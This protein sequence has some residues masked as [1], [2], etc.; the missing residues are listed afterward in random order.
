MKPRFDMEPRV[1]YKLDLNPVP[2]HTCFVSLDISEMHPNDKMGTTVV[3]SSK[4]LYQIS[5]CPSDHFTEY[6]ARRSLS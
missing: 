3:L 2:L 4:L 5:D 1:L 6:R